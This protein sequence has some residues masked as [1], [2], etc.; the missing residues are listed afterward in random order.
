MLDLLSMPGLFADTGITVFSTAG[1]PV[2]R[3]YPIALPIATDKINQKLNET[4]M[5]NITP[6]KAIWIPYNVA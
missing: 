5:R 2:K 3:K 4:M 6:L 1:D